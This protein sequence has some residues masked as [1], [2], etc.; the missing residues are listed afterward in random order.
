[1]GAC[2]SKKIQ[3]QKTYFNEAKTLQNPLDNFKNTTKVKLE[4]TIEGLQINR[5]YQVKAQ[6]VE[7][8]NNSYNSEV[9]TCHGNIISFNTCYIC[10][11]IFER[12][13]P[14]MIILISDSKAEGS[15][16]VALGNIV[17]SPGSVYKH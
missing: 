12:Q 8:N 4:F 14:L 13:Q 6:F 5:R 16:N 17:G 15:I 11:F 1:M 3:R 9:V 10:D 7:N 2:E